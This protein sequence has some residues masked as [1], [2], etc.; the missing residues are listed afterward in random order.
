MSDSATPP[1]EDDPVAHS[2]A[3]KKVEEAES[4]APEPAHPDSDE[5]PRLPGPAATPRPRP[6]A[7]PH[8]VPTAVPPVAPASPYA[9]A[10]APGAPAATGLREPVPP[11]VRAAPGEPAACHP[12]GRRAS[13]WNAA[14]RHAAVG[15]CAAAASGRAVHSR[16]GPAPAPAPPQQDRARQRPR[17]RHRG[18]REGARAALRRLCAGEGGDGAG[19]GPRAPAADREGPVPAP[20]GLAV[21]RARAVRAAAA[22]ADGRL[23]HERA[24][25]SGCS[26]KISTCSASWWAFSRRPCCSCSSGW[27]T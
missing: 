1:P 2:E 13:V 15:L 24:R 26:S 20:V 21:R 8:H 27:R 25:P 11:P 10:P 9:P 4:S 19:Q 3:A 7:V 23:R 16:H 18:R 17:H 5:G 12:T 6:L 14:A 22:R